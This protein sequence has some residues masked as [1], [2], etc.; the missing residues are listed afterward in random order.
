VF[1]PKTETGGGQGVPRPDLPLVYGYSVA[2]FS[3]SVNSVDYANYLR[4][5]GQAPEGSATGTPPLSADAWNADANDV[6]RIATGLWQHVDNASDVK[7]QTTLDEKAHG[8]LRDMGVL[9]PSYSLSLRPGW[10]RPGHPNLGDTVP[11]ELQ[12]GRIDDVADVPVLGLTYAIGDDGQED[13]DITVGRPVLTLA[14][15]FTDTRRDI[16]AL[17]RR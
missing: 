1:P 8:A 6:T 12:V 17:A 4:F 15:L 7:E 11:L 10:F 9:M 14:A 2:A 5:I 3:R 16:N 13:I